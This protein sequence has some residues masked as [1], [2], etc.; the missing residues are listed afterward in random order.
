MDYD[1]ELLRCCVLATRISCSDLL[2][3]P[4]GASE[5]AEVHVDLACI[6]WEQDHF[7]CWEDRPGRMPEL[8]TTFWVRT[9][10]HTLIVARRHDTALGLVFLRA[11]WEVAKASGAAES[12]PTIW[13]LG[14]AEMELV[15]HQVVH[16][17]DEDNQGAIHRLPEHGRVAVIA[18][19]MWLGGAG[20]LSKIWRDAFHV[21]P[22]TIWA[23]GLVPVVD[24]AIDTYNNDVHAVVGVHSGCNVVRVLLERVHH[25]HISCVGVG[26]RHVA[27]ALWHD[28]RVVV[29]KWGSAFATH[30][31]CTKPL[32]LRVRRLGAKYVQMKMNYIDDKNGSKDHRHLCPHCW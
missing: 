25:F 29:S 5:T 30:F 11:R 17:A 22:F 24:L 10:I 26:P 32:V 14:V 4:I 27:S 18:S 28:V 2:H 6:I 3:F 9:A 15:W 1:F 12:A 16:V 31:L 23:A 8:T 21:T 20:D 13:V 19:A 7:G